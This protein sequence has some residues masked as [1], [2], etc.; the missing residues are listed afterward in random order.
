M[1][2]TH[3][4]GAPLEKKNR[5]RITR[6]PEPLQKKHRSPDA[7]RKKYAWLLEDKSINEKKYNLPRIKV[8]VQFVQ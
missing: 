4:A 8:Y 1:F 2:L 7:R 5:S 6:A 3:G